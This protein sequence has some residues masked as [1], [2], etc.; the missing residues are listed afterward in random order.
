MFSPTPLALLGP[1]VQGTAGSKAGAEVRAHKAVLAARSP[2]FQRLFLSDMAES[3]TS[4]VA[5][6]FPAAVMELVLK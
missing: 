5:V 6:D 1:Q 3:R 2:V 4:T